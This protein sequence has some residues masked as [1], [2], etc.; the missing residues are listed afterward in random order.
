MPIE[1]GSD[2]NVLNAPD[3]RNNP[4]TGKPTI[5]LYV[6]SDKA[7]KFQP[8]L[9]FIVEKL[10]QQWPT[11]TSQNVH[12]HA[13]KVS[14]EIAPQPIGRAQGIGKQSHE[15]VAFSD[16]GALPMQFVEQSRETSYG[17]TA[18]STMEEQLKVSGAT[19]L[20]QFVGHSQDLFLKAGVSRRPPKVIE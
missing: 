1:A 18:G 12:L 14:S 15:S 19:W 3:F 4:D 5:E 17:H 10:S 13:L 6:T 20:E 11:F 2:P 8:A 9:N 16:G 7:L